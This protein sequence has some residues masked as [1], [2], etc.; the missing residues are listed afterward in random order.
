MKARFLPGSSSR[1]TSSRSRIGLRPVR[2]A[3]NRACAT[4]RAVRTRRSCPR[5][6]VRIVMARPGEIGRHPDADPSR[7]SR[8]AGRASGTP[9]STA[10]TSS[11]ESRPPHEGRYRIWTPSSLPV[12]SRNNGEKT[13]SKLT[14]QPALRF[15]ERKAH[16]VKL[17]HRRRQA[18][19]PCAPLRQRLRDLRTWRSPQGTRKDGSDS[20]RV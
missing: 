7:S 4:R 17:A 6:E 14:H 12:I 5:G 8:A 10:I 18:M 2:A 11:T 19:H 20:T 13:A 9:Q 3:R 15:L 1:S 16:G